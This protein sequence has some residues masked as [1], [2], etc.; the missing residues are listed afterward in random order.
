MSEHIECS[1]PLSI[2]TIR[3][4]QRQWFSWYKST[5]SLT[6]FMQIVW[7]ALTVDAAAEINSYRDKAPIRLKFSIFQNIRQLS[8]TTSKQLVKLDALEKGKDRSD[9]C[10]IVNLIAKLYIL[11]RTSH[12][13]TYSLLSNTFAREIKQVGHK[14]WAGLA[15]RRQRLLQATLISLRPTGSCSLNI[16]SPICDY[17]ARVVGIWIT[18]SIWH[19]HENTDLA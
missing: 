17:F 4:L 19:N 5:F 1:C 14:E 12:S 9:F 3:H 8:Y 16:R 18:L 10:E 11:L 13:Y 7:S 15:E 2:S 6:W